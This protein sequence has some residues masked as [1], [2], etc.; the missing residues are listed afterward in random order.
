[1]KQKFKFR[2]LM[3]YFYK[4]FETLSKKDSVGLFKIDDLEEKLWD[5]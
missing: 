1:M 5:L 4:G 3:K 2:R